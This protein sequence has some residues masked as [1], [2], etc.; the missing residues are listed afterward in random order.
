MGIYS[1]WQF[2]PTIPAPMAALLKGWLSAAPE[3]LTADAQSVVD[4]YKNLGTVKPPRITMKVTDGIPVLTYT[5]VPDPRN[6]NPAN[7]RFKNEAR[8]Y[9]YAWLLDPK[10]QDQ[11]LRILQ[12]D[13]PYLERLRS[14]FKDK[15]DQKT[16][17]VS[18]AYEAAESVLDDAFK[19]ADRAAVEVEN[20]IRVEA[21]RARHTAAVTASIIAAQADVVRPAAQQRGAC[22]PPRAT[23]Q[24]LT[25]EQLLGGSVNNSGDPE[26]TVMPGD[27]PGSFSSRVSEWLGRN[28]GAKFGSFDHA[29]VEEMNL[30]RT[31]AD[32]QLVHQRIQSLNDEMG[33]RFDPNNLQ[34]YN[35]VLNS[36]GYEIV[37]VDAS[38]PTTDFE[39][40]H[41]TQD[42]L[43]LV[44][45]IESVGEAIVCELMTTQ[46]IL[47]ANNV[48][49]NDDISNTLGRVMGRANGLQRTVERIRSHAS[50][51][52]VAEMRQPLSPLAAAPQGGGPRRVPVG[53]ALSSFG[54]HGQG[55]QF[56]P[57]LPPDFPPARGQ[58]RIRQRDPAPV[59]K[60]GLRLPS[61]WRRS[62]SAKDA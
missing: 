22:A 28:H 52:F 24:F 34:R 13:L 62:D 33:A 57:A 17:S 42:D 6:Q 46:D 18:R 37:F 31:L 23:T 10:N 29:S 53:E 54:G 58:P 5:D 41:G 51:D 16:Q 26:G 49:P 9:Y 60:R 7:T 44:R 45:D 1:E 56:P 11:A 40:T 15:I 35:A 3:S 12:R 38:L 2:D 14:A 27:A 30:P 59:A 39:L 61:S 55:A 36:L 4:V 19:V 47:E 48:A 43:R 32:L 8:E 20:S 25:L 21:E 50:Q